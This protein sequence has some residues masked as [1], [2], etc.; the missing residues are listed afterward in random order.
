MKKFICF[1]S[2]VS[3]IVFHVGA[4]P[5]S[6][7][8]FVDLGSST[9]D[10]NTQLEW[11]SLSTTRGMSPCEVEADLADSNTYLCNAMPG[12][13][14]SH[15]NSV[16]SHVDGWRF[17]S[18]ND[19][20]TLFDNWFGIL[21]FT[22]PI[23]PGT[24]AD[25]YSSH[26]RLYRAQVARLNSLSRHFGGIS[27]AHESDDTHTTSVIN[28]FVNMADNGVANMTIDGVRSFQMKVEH[29]LSKA[30]N[31]T[32]A[33]HIAKTSTVSADKSAGA[34]LVRDY[35]AVRPVTSQTTNVSAPITV[36]II[37]LAFAAWRRR[38]PA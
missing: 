24:Q 32:P 8:Q 1:L 37:L 17:A 31:E 22:Y 10:K 27:Y 36:G 30:E 38:Q 20:F 6:D 29:D 28:G 9:L 5:L 11:L 25:Q 15:L 14:A 4:T 35:K 12:G 33:L 2:L 7:G 34:W 26:P 3:A 23:I 19:V 13:D 21:N 16:V 18:Y